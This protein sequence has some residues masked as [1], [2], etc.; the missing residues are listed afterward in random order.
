MGTAAVIAAGSAAT[1]GGPAG[2][3]S[4]RPAQFVG[5]ISYSLYLVHWPLLII[6]QSAVG[7]Q[8]PLP[9]WLTVLLGVVVAVP[10][11]WLLHIAVEEPLRAARVLTSRRPR[12]TLWGTL[13]V[14]VIV[15]GLVL[16]AI[17]WAD[18]REV[19]TGGAAETVPAFP[20]SPPPSTEELPSNLSPSLDDVATDVPVL[21]EDGCHHDVATE[22]VQDCVYGPRD[23]DTTIAVFGDSHSAQWFPAIRTLAASR[24]DASVAAYTKSSCPAVTV[25]VLDKGVP[26]ESCDRWREAVL[27]HL[28]AAPPDLVLIS[29]YGSYALA[30]A[31]EDERAAAWAEGTAETVQR[32]R[33]AGSEVLMIADTPRFDSAPATCIATR[34]MALLDCAGDRADVLDASFARAEAAAAEGAGAR[35]VDLSS[36]LCDAMRCP[37]VIADLLVYRDVNHLT[38]RAVNYLAPALA[39]PVED[40]LDR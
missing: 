3:L 13:G 4:V 18:T 14:T 38:V 34:P 6:P 12:V 22:T 11:A 8:D 16:A 26:Y 20:I 33:A 30:D 17:A 9:L 24:G 29:S 27:A 19:P 32:L 23:A 1:V 39:G 5:K 28:V 35:F 31:G 7:F 25:T 36:Y 21:Y 10:V 40:L 15:A 37:V 2:V